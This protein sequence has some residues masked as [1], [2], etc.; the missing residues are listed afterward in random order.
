LALAARSAPNEEVRNVLVVLS[1]AP[2]PSQGIIRNAQELT[3]STEAVRLLGSRVVSIPT[4][5]AVSGSAE[6]AL[7]H[8]DRCPARARRARG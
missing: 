7:A 1:E 3:Q 6:N 4:D 5:F 2:V 8:I